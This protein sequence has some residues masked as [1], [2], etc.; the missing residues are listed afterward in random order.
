MLAMFM[1]DVDGFG[2]H[3]RAVVGAGDE[4]I[5]FW[6]ANRIGRVVA[7]T[8]MARLVLGNEADPS[9]LEDP[10]AHAPSRIERIG[11]R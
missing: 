6:L 10:R 11:S 9:M 4:R 3:E 7:P 2:R 1:E 8:S 5:A